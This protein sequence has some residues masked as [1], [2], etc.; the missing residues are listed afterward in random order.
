MTDESHDDRRPA[1]PATEVIPSLRTGEGIASTRELPVVPGEAA[2]P[3]ATPPPSAVPPAAPAPAAPP[4]PVALPPTTLPPT[5][6]PTTPPTTPPAA[7]PSAVPVTTGRSPRRRVPIV[8]VA[9]LA[10]VLAVAAA[11]LVYRTRPQDEAGGTTPAATPA[12]RPTPIRATISS[13]DPSGGSGFRQDGP[14][15]WRTQTYR[16]AEFGNLKPGVGL[17][18]DL[19][20]ARDVAVVTLTVEGGPVALELRAAD[21]QGGSAA[22]FAR[23]AAAPDASGATTLRAGDATAR[24]YWLVWVTRLAPQDGGYRAVLSDVTVRGQDG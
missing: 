19:G 4:P 24:R 6:P 20:A 13:F 17:L 12:A 21:Q 22:D 3:T 14:R 16:S 10:V 11:A 9:L 18:L 1:D 2:A 7:L 5:P 15:T 23:V 8:V